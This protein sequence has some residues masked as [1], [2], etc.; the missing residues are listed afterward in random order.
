MSAWADTPL[1]APD[2]VRNTDTYRRV[3]AA[4]RYAERGFDLDRHAESI[5]QVAI[6]A[7]TRH[8]QEAPDRGGITA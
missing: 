1:L 4:C 7:R 5:A 3:R 6:A 8:S 2:Q